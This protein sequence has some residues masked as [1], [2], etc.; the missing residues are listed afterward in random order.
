MYY[1]EY[2]FILIQQKYILISWKKG[3]RYNENIFY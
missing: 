2:K 3:D 1:I